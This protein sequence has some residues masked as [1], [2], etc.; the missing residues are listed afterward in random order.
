MLVLGLGI[1]LVMQVL[2]LAAQNSVDYKYLGVATSGSTLFRQI[3]GSIGVSIF[4]AIFANRLASNLEATI[5]P[6]AQ[7]SAAAN[8]SALKQLAPAVHDAYVTAIT[9]ALRRVFL[10]AAALAVL[11]FVLTWFLRELPLKATAQAPD[12]GDGFHPGRDAN[13]LREL[14]RPFGPRCPRAPLGDVPA[15]RRPRGAVDLAPPE[16]W[17]LAPLDPAGKAM[18]DSWPPD[19]PASTSF[20][21][22][23]NPTSTRAPTGGR[24]ARA[25]SR[26]PDPDARRRARLTA[27]SRGVRLN[28]AGVVRGDH[29][30]NT[31]ADAELSQ[32]VRD[33]RLDRRLAD[34]KARRDLRIGQ[35]AGDQP[36]DLD[37]ASGERCERT[38]VR[39]HP[40]LRRLEAFE[41]STDRGRAEQGVSARDDSDR[42]DEIGRSDVL[43][44]KGAGAGAD[45][46]VDVVVEVEGGQDEDAGRAAGGDDAPGGLDPVHDRHADVEEEHVRGELLDERHSLLPV[47]CLAHH[48]E[49]LARLDDHSKAAA[50]ERLVVGDRDANA[51]AADSIGISAATR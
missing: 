50:H 30:L 13:G 2:V 20:S 21:A 28:E 45:R 22:A 43:E 1:G 27:V 4:G 32:E 36:Q 3:G 40:V 15:P 48:L 18:S 38:V 6:G 23:G 10:T 14:E 29:R 8:P 12:L 47:F 9:A 17:L 46:T 16:L 7:V 24:Q 26:Q 41:Q 11:G 51:H 31:V 33:V 25:R 49:V 5:P 34:D 42:V 44:Q 39:R 19:A 35:A 37:L